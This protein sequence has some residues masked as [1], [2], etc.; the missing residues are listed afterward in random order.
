MPRAETGRAGPG[1]DGSGDGPGARSGDGASAFAPDRA[2]VHARGLLAGTREPRLQRRHGE[3][4]KSHLT[5]VQGLVALSLD[6]LSSV[7]YGPEAIAL[8]LVTAGVARVR[9]TLPVTLV[10]TVLLTVLVV[11]YRQVIAVHPDGGGSYAVARD[12]I[13]PRVG[14]LAA[15]ALVVDYVLTVAVSLAAGAATLASAFPDLL[16]Y[17]LE[18]SL[19]V[20]AVL[21]AVN[22]YGIAESARF[23]MT[24]TLLFIAAVLGVIAAG[25]VRS[26]PVATVGGGVAPHAHEALGIMLLLKAFS[27]GCTAL[28]GVEAIAN[29]VPVFREPRVRRAQRTELMLGALLGVMLVGLALLIRRDEVVPRTGVTIFAQ[30]TAGAFG[31]GWP[32]RAASVIVA[33]ALALA[34]N[35]S[36]GGLPVLLSLLARDRRLPRLFAL[37][38]ER[39]VHRYGVLAVAVVAAVL[40]VAV[41]ARTHRLLPLYAIGVF[42][43]FTISQTGLVLHWARLRPPGWTRKALLN[44]T[45]AVLT[46]VATLVLLIT[47][48]TEGAWAVAVVIPLLVLLLRRVRRYYDRVAREL[49]FGRVPAERPRPSED[50]RLVILPVDELSAVT[51]FALSTA[52][53]LGGEVRALSVAADERAAG[54]LRERWERWDPGVPLEILRSP[55]ETRIRPVVDHVR[56][57]AARDGRTVVVLV[58]T[59]ESS[60]P[61]YRFL[62][63]QWSLLLAEALRERVPGVLICL[64]PYRV[65]A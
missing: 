15:A 59:I 27:S 6:A 36:F 32:Y 1:G 14:T 35:T 34:A 30:L 26:G 8:V 4:D 41:D 57:I 50:A 12:N 53:G 48:F 31:T 22:L 20:L 39:P 52:L 60:R 25:L 16:P 28:T 23:L 5:S 45:G 62:Y 46:A 65:T 24:P 58:P 43:G 18:T 17:L 56:R 42:T 9:L 19:A 44:G 3:G 21:T 11:S 54:V 51:A 13:G 33:V 64:L 40:L 61:R 37:R 2:L 10:I 38:G 63:D 29:G 55:R 49:G 47:K 7:A